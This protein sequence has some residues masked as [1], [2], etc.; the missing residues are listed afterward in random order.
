MGAPNLMT[1][2]KPGKLQIYS[3]SNI[4]KFAVYSLIGSFM[5]FIP[6][7]VNDVSSIPIDHIV[8]WI[9]QSF[10]SF[11]SIYTFIVILLGALYPFVSK[12]WNK[13][14]VTMVFSILKVIGFSV[15]VLIF[16]RLGPAWL[17]APNMGPFLFEKLV[18]SFGLVVPIGSLFLGLL[19]GYGLL[20]FI[21]VL[22][23]PIMRPVWKTPGRSAVDLVADLVGGYSLGLLMTNRL[24]KEGKYTALVTVM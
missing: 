22:M 16:F 23:Q 6:M 12:T 14:K 2:G 17:M 5:F 21:G 11:V 20:E 19:I 9:K 1:D 18:V 10:P 24:F 7:T 15:A 3:A 4:L 8:T 13:D